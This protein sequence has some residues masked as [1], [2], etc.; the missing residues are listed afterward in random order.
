MKNLTN[1][2]V[3]LKQSVAY[4]KSV[5]KENKVCLQKPIKFIFVR[6]AF[7]LVFFKLLKNEESFGRIS[8]SHFLQNLLIETSNVCFKN[9]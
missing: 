9:F 2:E 7:V 4:K 1:T 3:E 8:P 5:Y 6:T